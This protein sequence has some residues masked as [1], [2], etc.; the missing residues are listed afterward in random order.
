M[1]LHSNSPLV[2]DI[3]T[4]EMIRSFAPP[5][6]P[7]LPPPPPFL[8]FPDYLPLNL[9]AEDFPSDVGFGIFFLAP[10]TQKNAEDK[11]QIEA[12]ASVASGAASRPTGVEHNENQV[13][14]SRKETT[15]PFP[16]PVASGTKRLR[17]EP[18]DQGAIPSRRRRGKAA[19]SNTAQH[20]NTESGKRISTLSRSGLD[21]A[22]RIQI[23]NLALRCGRRQFRHKIT[24]SED[25]SSRL[26]LRMRMRTD[27]TRLRGNEQYMGSKA[28]SYRLN[29]GESNLPSI[30]SSEA[31]PHTVLGT[32][33]WKTTIFAFILL[34]RLDLSG[35]VAKGLN[36]RACSAPGVAQP[37]PPKFA[38]GDF[39]VTGWPTSAETSARYDR[40]CDAAAS[41]II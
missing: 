37:P 8:P 25:S 3:L 14:I 31:G 26:Q 32:S 5:P 40:G 34:S 11:T 20:A 24:N 19:G 41:V 39:P 12:A 4:K 28:R 9:F 33:Q 17:S 2:N 6:T 1:N 30:L 35:I 27:V 21:K 36:L 10:T 22:I 7:H 29:L 18:L 16:C 38:T 13:S 15:L 23:S